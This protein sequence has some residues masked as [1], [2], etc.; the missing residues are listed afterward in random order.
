[1][2]IFDNMVRGAS[3]QFG[4]EFGRAGANSIL[5]GANSYTINNNGDSSGRIKPSDSDVIKAIKEIKKIKFISTNKGN[6]SRLIE[7][8]GLI[9]SNLSF[10]GNE[11]LN[12]VNDVRELITTAITK[13]Q[14]GRSLIDDDFN[15]KSLEY[16][17]EQMEEALVLIDEFDKEK[18]DFIKTN[19]ELYGKKRKSKIITTLLA[20]PFLGGLG[21]HKFYLNKIMVGFIYLIFCA[22]FIPS[23]LSFFEFLSCVFMSKEKFDAKYNPEYSYYN[24]FILELEVE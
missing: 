13:Y 16:L 12:Q 23:I 1:M 11:T 5:K 14:Q 20:F 10:E 8:A 6:V 4:R 3:S 19:L 7:V 22:T 21:V 18:S 9:T 2:G 24:Q 17:E 15:D